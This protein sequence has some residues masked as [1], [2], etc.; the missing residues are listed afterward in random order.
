MMGF[1]VPGDAYDR[2][3]GRYSVKFAPLLADFAGVEAGMRVLDVGAGPGALT[4]ELAKRVGA[5]RVAA[6]DPS[7]RFVAAC[8]LRVPGVDVRQAAAEALPWPVGTFDAVLAQLVVNF[9]R[10]AELGAREMRRVVRASGVVAACTFDRGEGVEML[11]A[12]S[13][14]A[15]ALDPQALARGPAR[16][17]RT[18][19]ELTDLWQQ[20]GLADVETGSLVV[21]AGYADFD[22]L[23][24]GFLTGIGPDSA[25]CVSLGLE[26]QS[27]L[28]EEF[29]RRLGSPPGEFTLS[30]RAWA[31]RGRV[32][33][34]RG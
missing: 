9:F 13:Q 11:H 32:R 30:A 23:W 1:E 6:I 4:T 31:V 21:D 3:I 25:Y 7:D 17:Y 18:P 8:R 22:D 24:S 14:A 29:R 26:R 2:L 27:A 34:A 19:D 12:F 16:T 10:D 5:D 15:R 33:A 28:R 20:A